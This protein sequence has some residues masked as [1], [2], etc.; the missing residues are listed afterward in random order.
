[1]LTIAVVSG[2]AAYLF[3]GEARRLKEL[4]LRQ[5]RSAEAYRIAREVLLNEPPRH[6]VAHIAWQVRVVALQ[7]RA[8]RTAS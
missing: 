1:M 5:R 7:E 3:G 8:V 6:E 4:E 2:L